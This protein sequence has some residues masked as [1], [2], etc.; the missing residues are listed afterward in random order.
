MSFSV[1]INDYILDAADK[2]NHGILPHAL[3]ALG[4]QVTE[5]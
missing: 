1:Q 4:I 5:H 2:N 3:P